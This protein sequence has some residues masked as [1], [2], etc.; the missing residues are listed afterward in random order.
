[1]YKCSVALATLLLVHLIFPISAAHAQIAPSAIEM[2]T[3][4]IKRGAHLR[5][6]RGFG[7]AS[8]CFAR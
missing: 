6:A 8:P 2:A 3:G 4:D 5:P 1:M 7:V